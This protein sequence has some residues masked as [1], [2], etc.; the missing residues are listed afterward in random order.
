VMAAEVLTP[1][2]LAHRYGIEDD[3]GG[4]VSAERLLSD[5]RARMVT[6]IRGLVLCGASV[7]PVGAV[8]GRAARLVVTE[9]L[10]TDSGR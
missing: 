8:S 6:P 5:W 4:P 9:V 1:D 7:D 2:D 10:R 3:F